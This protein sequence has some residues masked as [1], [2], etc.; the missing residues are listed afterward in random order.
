MTLK[1]V[2]FEVPQE[3]GRYCKAVREFVRQELDPWGERLEGMTSTPKEL[4]ALLRESGL[5]KLTMPREYGGWSL[6]MEQYA[7]ILEEVAKTQGTIR[8]IVHT[9]NGVFMRGILDYGTPEMREKYLPIIARGEWIAG[10]ALTEPGTGTGMDI[11]TTATR[12]GSNFILNGRKHLISLADI[13]SAFHVPTWTDRSLGRRGLTSFLVEKGSPGF[14]VLEM[15]QA[16][17]NKGSFHGELIFE[18]CVVPEKNIIGEMGQGIDIALGILDLSR[19]SIAV[20]CL[21]LAQRFLELSVPYT[22]RRVTFGKPIAERQAVQQIVA[23]MATDIY[24]LRAMVNDVAQKSDRGL[25]IRKESSMCKLFG[26]ETLRRVGDNALI[27]HGGLGYFKTFTIERMYRDSRALW[28]E[29][30]TPM[31]QR[32]V[33]ARDV[34]KEYD[35]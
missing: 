1:A 23:D 24:A 7:P 9:W 30:G 31:I 26:L 8:L 19:F 29:E 25:P 33:I 15:P 3:L 2:D 18:D 4:M 20:S 10:Y 27:V 13:C 28:F 35:Q 14:T 5:L 11:K 16:M 21:G 32:L 6:N 34:L 17:G 12:D 22:H